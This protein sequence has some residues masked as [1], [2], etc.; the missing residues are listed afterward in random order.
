MLKTKRWWRRIR[1]EYLNRARHR[2]IVSLL[3]AEVFG[4]APVTLKRMGNGGA[5]SV[6][7]VF[8]GKDAAGILRVRNPYQKPRPSAL[9]AFLALSQ[10]SIDREWAVYTKGYPAGLTPQPLWRCEDAMLCAH[11]PYRPLRDCLNAKNAPPFLP[12]LLRCAALL[13]RLHKTGLSHMDAGLGNV[14]VDEN[15]ENMTLIDFEHGP[16]EN[17]SFP[18]QCL[19]DHLKLLN[20]ALQYRP[21]ETIEGFSLWADNFRSGLAGDSS[22]RA[23]FDTP[24]AEA[25][26]D[27]SKLPLSRLVNIWA[28]PEIA[29]HIRALLAGGPVRQ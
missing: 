10:S 9:N 24:A 19:Y 3:R 27:E 29:A 23:Y 17:F 11:L 7:K 28:N 22:A 15:F 4:G 14:L 6:Y 2:Q 21:A 18:A 13:D 26:L 5:D 1:A 12:L 16:A 20:T 8:L 25:A